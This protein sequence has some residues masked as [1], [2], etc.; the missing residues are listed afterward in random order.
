MAKTMTIA[1][2]LE[3]IV[4]PDLPIAIEAYDGSRLGPP[5][6]PATLYIRS[7]TALRRIVQAPGELGFGRAYVAGDLDL[8]G[9]IFA[10]LALRDR[11]PDLKLRPAH[12]MAALRLV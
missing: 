9:D 7:Q 12:W 3:Q 4:G 2:L 10:A 1:D 8:G 6:P 5:D 11:L